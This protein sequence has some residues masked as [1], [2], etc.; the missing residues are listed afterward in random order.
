MDN[1]IRIKD[2][3]FWRDKEVDLRGSTIVGISGL[4]V[5]SDEVFFIFSDGRKLKMYHSQDCCEEVALEEIHGDVEWLIGSPLT[6]FDE[7]ISGADTSS[8]TETWTFYQIST[9]KGAVT[10]KWHGESNG[11]YSES[12]DFKWI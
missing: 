10:L 3:D 12:V 9:V 1:L 5:D 11:Y 4:E 7:R 2:K 6:E 8:G